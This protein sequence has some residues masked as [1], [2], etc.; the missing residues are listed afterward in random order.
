VDL[1]S[2]GSSESY[3]DHAWLD[4]TLPVEAMSFTVS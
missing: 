3:M 2:N 1:F 4:T